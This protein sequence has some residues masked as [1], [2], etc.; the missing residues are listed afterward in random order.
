M[1][2]VLFDTDIL[3]TVVRRDPPLGVIRRLAMIPPSC[4]F[5]TSIS[6]GEL[7]Y[8]DSARLAS[9]YVLHRDPDYELIFV[10]CRSQTERF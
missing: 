6:Y 7:V 1:T 5:T 9:A 8:S 3:L 2:N 4:Q 10:G